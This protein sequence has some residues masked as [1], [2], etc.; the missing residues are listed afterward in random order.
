MNLQPV[1][2]ADIPIGTA[3]PWQLFDSQGYTLFARGEVIAVRGQLDGLAADGLL[4][5]VDALPQN[6]P[7]AE[8]TEFKGLPPGELFPPAGIRPQIGEKIQLRLLGQDIQAYYYAHLIGY[9]KDQ[10]ILLTTP[11]LAGQRIDMNEGER[12]ELRM[13][14][15]SNIYIFQS[16][17][18]RVCTSP[19]H[20]MHLQYP[21]RIQLQKLRSGCRTRVRISAQ[22]TNQQGEQLM[23]EISDLSAAGAQVILPRQYSLKGDHLRLSFPASA[24]ELSTSLNLDG[25]VKHQRP[26]A[27]GHEWGAEMLEYGIAFANVSN[28]DKLWLKCLVYQH[29]AEGGLV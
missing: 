12:V 6:E 5:D 7:A 8:W 23:A 29:I 21:N 3:L 1:A 2:I 24:D 16:E 4:R 18:L 22:V 14:T 15:G 19:W 26:A 10:S 25:V 9:I 27:P 13:L 20:Y 17:I 11:L 28:Q